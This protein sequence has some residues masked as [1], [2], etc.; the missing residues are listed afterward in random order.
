MITEADIKKM[1]KVFATKDDLK[2][3]ATKDDLPR[4]IREELE[5]QKP[6]W[7]R[8]ISETVTKA[9]GDKL[10]KHYVLLDKTFG[11]VKSMREVQEIHQ[12][13]HDRMNNR[14]ERLEKKVN[15]PPFVD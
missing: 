10:D 2:R 12:G 13:D 3:F 9:L 11:E 7:V 5:A 1:Q 14:L 6:E 8:V 4:S 15:L